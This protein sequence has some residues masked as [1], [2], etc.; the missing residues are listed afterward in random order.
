LIVPISITFILLIVLTAARLWIALQLFLTARRSHL[1]NLYWLAGLFAL[2]VYSIFTP[3]SDSPLASYPLFFMGY[4][5]GHF[6]LAIFIHTTF[7]RDRQ[8]PLYLVLGLLAVATIVTIYALF[9]MNDTNLAGIMSSVG[10]VNWAW[11][12]IVARSAYLKIVN[13][14]EVENWVKG[15]YRLMIVYIPMMILIT[16]QVV[17]SST[18]ISPYL[19]RILLPIGLLIIIASIILQFLVWVMP[20]PFRLWLNQTKQQVRP[21]KEPK[22]APNAMDVFGNAMTHDTGLNTIACF[23]AIRSTV[24]KKIG[25]QDSDAVR[26]YIHGMTYYEWDAIFQHT[27]LNRILINGGADKNAAEKAI[28]NARQALVEKQSL[29]TLSTH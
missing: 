16:A 11:H 22:T 26:E 14:P 23:Y 6:C 21:S 8:S 7:H 4:L 28:Q 9:V 12:F 25:T 2:A 29:L 13:D 15:R 19:P 27:E 17:A 5:A 10:L 18:N 20:E 24:A 3:T 1:N